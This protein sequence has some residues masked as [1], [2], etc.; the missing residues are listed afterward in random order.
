MCAGSVRRLK[1]QALFTRA[2]NAPP[3]LHAFYTSN[4][5]LSKRS[6]ASSLVRVGL[7]W[8]RQQDG[9]DAKIS[10]FR[11]GTAVMSF[12]KIEKAVR[13]A[14]DQTIQSPTPPALADRARFG[15]L[16]TYSHCLLASRRDRQT[17]Q[18]AV[19]SKSLLTI[20]DNCKA[21]NYAALMQG[22]SVGSQTT[23]Y[24]AHE[25][26]LYEV[27]QRVVHVTT[28]TFRLKML[29]CVYWLETWQANKSYRC[30]AQ[31]QT[32]ISVIHWQT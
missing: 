14:S 21:D 16:Y 19:D 30:D 10:S 20:S 11:D 25:R 6:N 31:A 13:T 17:A 12:R 24:R 5:W 28:L 15:E 26:S 3:V 29:V 2:H 9:W 27:N 1:R 7:E 23:R 18:D 32:M 4:S 22:L 8:A